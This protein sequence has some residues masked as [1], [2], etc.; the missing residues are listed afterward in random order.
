VL[1]T[2]HGSGTFVTSMDPSL[3]VEP[4]EFMFDTPGSTMLHLFE[5]RQVIEANAARLAAMRITDAELDKIDRI[6]SEAELHQD[7]PMGFLAYDFDIHAAIIQATNNPIFIKIASSIA[8]LSRESRKRTT[9][10]PEV[11]SHAH[12]DHKILATHLRAHDPDAAQ[13]AMERHLEAVKAGYLEWLE[14]RQAGAREA[15]A[16]P[17][18]PA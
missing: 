12:D 6:V 15:E 5:T 17:P 14:G 11:R 3:L 9:W 4:I 13:Q 1:E 10:L 2:H 18:K 8:R 16:G 7:D